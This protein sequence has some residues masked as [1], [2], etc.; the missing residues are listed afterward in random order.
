[1]LGRDSIIHNFTLQFS[2]SDPSKVVVTSADSLVRVLCGL[3]VICKF[4][5][6]FLFLHLNSYLFF[7]FIWS[8]MPSGLRSV[9]NQT[10]ASFTSDGKH[11]ISTSEDF[12]VH[13]WNYASQE[14]TSRAKNIQSCESFL[15]QNASVAIP[16]RG[17]ETIPGTPS[18][19]ESTCGNSFKGDHTSPKFCREL[20]QK[21]LSSSSD[22]FSLAR[23]FLLESSTRGS[24]TWP[25][26]KLPNSSPKTASLTKSRPEFKY[27]KNACHNM[28]SSHL[29][30]LVI[31]T[32]GWDGRIRTYSTMG[33]LSDY[34]INP[35]VRQINRGFNFHPS[36][37]QARLFS[38]CLLGTMGGDGVYTTD[39]KKE[40]KKKEKAKSLQTVESS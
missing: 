16:W 38:W 11:I 23:G 30:G 35:W 17:I 10:S 21:K 24:A 6:W 22:C 3:D 27:L 13:V 2:P 12:N 31:V 15:S 32:A 1:M 37:I 40:K 26:E 14:R 4:S 7:L 18:S 28:L 8:P 34:E 5:G 9:A 39:E 20:D 19:L 25:E 29:W 33:Y 36:K